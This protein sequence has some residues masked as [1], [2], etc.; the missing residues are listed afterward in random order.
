MERNLVGSSRAEYPMV[1]NLGMEGGSLF[2]RG[3]SVSPRSVLLLEIRS[4]VEESREEE[5]WSPTE[6]SC[7]T[8]E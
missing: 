2:N 5:D 8:E 7:S 3:D 4:S 1:R 6:D